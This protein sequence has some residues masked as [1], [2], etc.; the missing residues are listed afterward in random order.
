M[1]F[2]FIYFFEIFCFKMN[3]ADNNQV[4]SN[5]SAPRHNGL[6]DFGKIVIKEMNRYIV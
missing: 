1:R 3:R 6:T 4:D 2:N 5:S